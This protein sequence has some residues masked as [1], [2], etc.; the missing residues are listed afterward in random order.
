MNFTL[1]VHRSSNGCNLHAPSGDHE[2]IT[3]T[4]FQA[5]VDEQLRLH[6]AAQVQACPLRRHT[7]DVSE[8]I[9]SHRLD[10][11]VRKRSAVVFM[12]VTQ[13]TIRMETTTRREDR[14]Q[15]NFCLQHKQP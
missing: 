2:W 12:S 15:E 6:V 10:H 3:G 14:V 4:R 13:V 5:T 8:K 11:L 7:R 1:V 9:E